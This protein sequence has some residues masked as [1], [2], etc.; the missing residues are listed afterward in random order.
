MKLSGSHTLLQ[1][2][3]GFFRD[4][5]VSMQGNFLLAVSG[6]V[7]SVVLCELSRQAGINFIVAHCNFGLRGVESDRDEAF[8]KELGSRYGTAVFVKSFDTGVYAAAQKLSIQ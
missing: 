8:V 3:I 7:D 2:F 6:G 4:N 1:E 5:Q